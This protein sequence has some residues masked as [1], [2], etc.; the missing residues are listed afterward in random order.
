[1]STLIKL[2]THPNPLSPLFISKLN[3]IE[4][5]ETITKGLVNTQLKETVKTF[6]WKHETENP[7]KIK[8]GSS[9]NGGS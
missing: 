7:H 8:S 6:W 1:M 2:A 4:K 3:I 5:I 9:S